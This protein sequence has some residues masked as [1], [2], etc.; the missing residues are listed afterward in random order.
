MQTTY[1]DKH[2]QYHMW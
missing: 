2:L 1:N